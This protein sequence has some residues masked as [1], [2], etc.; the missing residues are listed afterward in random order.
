[1]KD[2]GDSSSRRAEGARALEAEA[3]EARS[4]GGAT[5]RS[6]GPLP[7]A[8]QFSFLADEMA[9]A[10]HAA[11][12]KSPT[13]LRCDACDQPIEGEAAGSG[14]YFWSRDGEVRWEEPALCEECATAIGVTALRR[15]AIED[16]EG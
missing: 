9:Q 15:W 7:L 14:L 10:A 6:T 11:R 3:K 16:D 12:S 4:R 13:E 8:P 1:M 2:G 5:R